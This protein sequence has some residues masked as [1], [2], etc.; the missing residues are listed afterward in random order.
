[1]PY[2]SFCA[3]PL[4]A[5]PSEFRF[6]YRLIATFAKSFVANHQLDGTQPPLVLLRTFK[7]L[8]KLDHTQI[9]SRVP[10]VP[11]GG[12]SGRGSTSRGREAHNSTVLPTAGNQY[13]SGR[14][15]N[16]ELPVRK[17]ETLLAEAKIGFSRHLRCHS[18]PRRLR[19]CIWP[20]PC[21]HFGQH[22]STF[23]NSRNDPESRF[24]WKLVHS[25]LNSQFFGVRRGCSICAVRFANFIGGHNCFERSC[26]RICG[27]RFQRNRQQ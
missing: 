15:V 6:N 4:T 10:R 16:A 13:R 9:A 3:K 12:G 19:L 14:N 17:S 7:T 5:F 26:G 8:T 24:D 21:T 11:I 18:H 1:M 23:R 20:G 2:S 27:Q 25:N 22:R